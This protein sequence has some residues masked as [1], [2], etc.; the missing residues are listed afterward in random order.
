MDVIKHRGAAYYPE[1]WPEERWDEDIRLMKEAG[2]NLIR[3]GEFAWTAMEPSEGQFTLDW[4]HR[5]V[6]KLG[7]AGINVLLCTPT[8]APPAW[9]TTQ[10]TQTLLVRRDGRRAAH[11]A[12][13]HYCP[14]NEIYRGHVRRITERLSRE[15][16]CHD[17]IIA[18]QIDNEIG[19]EMSYCHCDHCSA[20]F[21]AWLHS[22]YGTLEALNE[23]W[24]T[25][26]WSVTFTEWQ[27]IHLQMESGYP[28]IELDMRRFYSDSYI[29]FARYQAEIIRTN[30]PQAKI[31]TNMVAPPLLPYI[32]YYKMALLFDI[33]ADDLYFDI[34]TM[35]ANALACDF[36][37]C[38]GPS[39][40]FWLTETGISALL[41]RKLPDPRQVRAWAF[42]ALAR[43][44]EAHIF[45]RWRTCPAGQEQDLQGILESSG[46]PHRR[47]ETVRSLFAEMARLEPDLIGLPVPQAEVAMI[48]SYDVLWAYESTRI[49]TEVQYVSH[50]Q[51]LYKLLFDGKVLTDI[52]PP[53][54]DLSQYRL[55]ILPSLCISDEDFIKR[56]RAFVTNGG[57]VIASP[58]LANRNANNNYVSCPTPAALTDLF[59][60]EVA[61]HTYLDSAVG[62]DEAL[63]APVPNIVEEV[64]TVCLATGI[65][66]KASRYMEDLTLAG[67]QVMGTYT[68]NLFAGCPAVVR[69]ETGKGCAWYLAAYL[70]QRLM[71]EVLS[72]ALS[73]AGVIMGP[74][75]P[76]WVEIIRRGDITFIINHGRDVAEINLGSGLALIGTI[77]DG[78]VRLGPLDV[79]VIR[80]LR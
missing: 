52:I 30:H 42:S 9:L 59:G 62:P 28:S 65:E 68:D 19:P 17:N 72:Q 4:L 43:G 73:S 71:N 66:G 74:V 21:R 69:H 22:R 39:Q 51:S 70:D 10:Y 3:I 50:F 77:G 44:S 1:F 24:Q 54:R 25:R 37:R 20:R 46:K 16:A 29:D 80:S 64:V 35:D 48:L 11:G 27:Q 45:F 34:G 5:I 2:I 12:R 61:S 36:L 14:T 55:V 13:R 67:G 33:I 8:A 76:P 26:F 79:A 49:G 56:L 60:L 75:T 15:F 47:Y 7:E 31:T 32:D 38:L 40:S 63:W 23:A 6:A 41:A 53:D 57:V 18:W 78:K 58:Q